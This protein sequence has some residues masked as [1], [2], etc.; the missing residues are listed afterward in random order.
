[1]TLSEKKINHVAIIPDGNR[2]WAKERGMT[3]KQGHLQGYKNSI[4]L[5]KKAR[6]LDITVLTF[7]AFST[8]NWSRTRSE[9]SY[10]MKIYETFIDEHLRE[11]LKNE[12]RLTHLGRKDRIPESLLTKITNA[13]N[14]TKHF[15]TRYLNIAL[16]YGGRDE[17]TRAINKLLA[18]NKVQ[19]TRYKITEAQFGK[20]LDTGFLPFPDPDIIIRTGGE[21]R[22]SGFLLY[23]SA[24]SEYYFPE[25]MFPDFTPEKLEA[26]VRDFKNRQRRFGK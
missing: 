13:E 3:T 26:I 21:Y 24:Y 15:T 1:M 10:L 12:T 14:K 4:G 16:D 7:W 9:V 25:E 22:T 20:H 8:E 2:R 6:E 5:V 19:D 17:I 23:Q 18:S 11:A